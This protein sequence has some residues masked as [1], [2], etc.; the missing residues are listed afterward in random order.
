MLSF[1]TLFLILLSADASSIVIS[2]INNIDRNI[3]ENPNIRWFFIHCIS[4]CFVAYYGISDLKKCLRNPYEIDKF[5]W[6]EN[7]WNVMNMANLTHFY[8]CLFFK[9]TKADIIHHVSMVAIAGSIEYYQ[10]NI[11]CPAVLF[12][13]SGFPGSIDYFL[14]FLVKLDLFSKNR[15]KEIYLYITTYIRGPGACILSYIS[16]YNFY[17]TNNFNIFYILSNILVFWN[18]QYYLMK[19]SFDYGKYLQNYKLQKIS[20]VE[21]NSPKNQRLPISPEKINKIQK[22]D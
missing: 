10:Q 18:G 9:L 8:H 4:N 22:I 11:I 21:K 2:K 19:H 6:D 13:L 3:R 16:L 5:S 7:S 14:L 1:L 15:E 17:I 12:F 20:W